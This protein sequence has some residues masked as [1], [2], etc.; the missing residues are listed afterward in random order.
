[1]EP[2]HKNP[3]LKKLKPLIGWKE[4]CALPALGIEMIKAKVDTGASTSALHAIV[5]NMFEEKGQ[6]FISF[7]VYLDEGNQPRR[8]F[9][10]AQLVARRFVMSSNGEREKRYVIRTEITVGQNNFDT[11]ITLTDRSPLRYRMLLGRQA[12]RVRFLIDPSK[13]HMQGI[14]VISPS[15]GAQ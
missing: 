6:K 15:F 13:T 8:K 12:L 5:L 14:P 10:K 3:T 11:Q 7:V 4:W 1:M 9:C 2:Q